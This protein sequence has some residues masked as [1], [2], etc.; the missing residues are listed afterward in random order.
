MKVSRFFHQDAVYVEQGDTLR[1]AA[2]LMQKG[3]FSCLPVLEDSS[4]IGIIMERDLVQA[5]AHGARPADAHVAEYMHDAPVTVTLDDDS[6]V[7]ATKMLAIGC[8]HLPVL[9]D[10]KLVGMVALRDL[11]LAA[12]RAE[13]EAEAV[14]V[15]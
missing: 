7:A 3:G 8:R 13:A 11:Y 14:L 1:S 15:A 12:V 10:G 4:V 2:N 9:D 6:L 5:V